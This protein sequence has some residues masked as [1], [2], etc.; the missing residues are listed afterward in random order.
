[1]FFYGGGQRGW[2]DII[3]W[4]IFEDTSAL[5]WIVLTR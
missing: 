2:H 5:F 3:A 1:L 4:F